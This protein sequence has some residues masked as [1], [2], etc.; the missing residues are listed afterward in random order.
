[1]TTDNQAFD[2][3]IV[4]QVG[5][6]QGERDGLTLGPT[7]LDVDGEHA[8]EDD[9]PRIVLCTSGSV[10]VD[11]EAISPGHAVLV[12]AGGSAGL[13]GRGRVFIAGVGRTG[14]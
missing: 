14:R 1:M 13:T 4:Q 6:G 7:Q 8:L 11:G 2:R 12:T 5:Q 10:Q 3:W 9:G